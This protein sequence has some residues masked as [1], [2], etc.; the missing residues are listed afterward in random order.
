[1]TTHADTA[2]LMSAIMM[3]AFVPKP[4]AG[5]MAAAFMAMAVWLRHTT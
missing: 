5:M 2:L 1:M 4:V 3:A